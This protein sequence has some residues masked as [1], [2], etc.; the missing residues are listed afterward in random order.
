M[1]INVAK[2]LLTSSFL[3]V[4]FTTWSV[5]PV[6]VNYYQG[7]GD[8]SDRFN[9]I[10]ADGQGNYVAV[11]Y[12]IKTGDYRDFLIVKFNSN[13]DT[14]W[15]RTKNGKDF[16][17]DEAVDVVLDALGNVYACGYSDG[18]NSQDDILL[19]KYDAN[20]NELYDTTWN[21]SSYYMD[22]IPVA[23][24]IDG[25]QN[26]FI[27]GSTEPDTAKGSNNFITLKFNSSGGLI[28]Q[29]EYNRP[30]VTSGKDEAASI[31]VDSNGDAYITGR[32]SN[33]S[34]DDIVTI[35]YNGTDGSTLWT[36]IYNSGNGDDRGTSLVVDH[37]GDIIITGRSDNGS[38][39]DIRTV[40]YSSTGTLVWSRAYNGP[41]NQN[42]RGLGVIVDLNDNVLV[43]GQ[44]DSNNSA[45]IDYDYVTVKYNASGIIQWARFEASNA[46][47][48]DIPSA[49]AT[50]ASGNVFVTGKSD[51]D[52]GLNTDNDYM[53]VM[54]NSS[55]VKQWVKFHSGSRLAGS[56]IA[57]SLV[58]DDQGFVYVTGGSENNVTQK[59][60][61][62]VKYDLAGNEIWVKNLNGIGDFSE[63]ARAV[64]IDNNGNAY[65]GGYSFQ[66]GHNRDIAIHAM[67]NAGNTICTWLYN[68][69]KNDDDEIAAMAI[70]ASGFVYATGFTKVIDQKSDMITLKWNPATCDTV[71][72]RLY[73]YSAN[74]T[75]KGMSIVVDAAGN[76]YVTGR[77]DSN[78]NDTLDNDDIVTFKYD[79][80]GNLIWMQRYDGPGNKKDE[81][82]RIRLD[83][84]GNV[85]V[86]GRTEKANDD[87]FFL[88]KYNSITGNPVWS[89]PALFNGP[90]SN[91]DRALDMTIDSNDNIYVAG[92][93]QTGSAGSADDGLVIKYD[94]AGNLF[95]TQI[96]F[97][98]TFSGLGNDQAVGIV[99]N[100][101]N[102]I[103]VLY[104][105]DVNN[106][107]NT[108]NYNYLTI[109]YDDQFNQLWTTPPQ[110]DGPI[111]GD[112]IP[113]A[114]TASSTGDIFVTGYSE[115]DSAG[116]RK[117]QN[118]VTL[119]YNDQGVQ[120]MYENFDG[121][122]ATDDQPNAMAIRGSKLWVAGYAEGS[123]NNQKDLTTVTYDILTDVRYPSLASAQASIY[124]N[125]G[126]GIF[127]IS[128]AKDE[129]GNNPAIRITDVPG[130]VVMEQKGL[131][132]G[133]N[134]IDASALNPGVYVYSIS[135]KDGAVVASGTFIVQ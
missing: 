111:H 67:D 119:R 128:W 131:P 113:I 41:A 94:S 53:T 34:D 3:F 54:Y 19:V 90:F 69:N 48:D 51:Q 29:A 116:G 134:R 11:G 16:M 129:F 47:Q 105:T 121:P 120:T 31:A 21:N 99:H 76:S 52:P 70:D 108:S 59:D 80:N 14:L 124:P 132:G 133:V 18:G 82:S 45:T 135:S 9:K 32:S 46:L 44:Y 71:W 1:K 81:P 98:Y 60:A 33:G 103:F 126:S 35:K 84:S 79:T 93:M 87:D 50:D 75:D 88:V 61:T 117:N 57:S 27:T 102:E 28:W 100:Q 22:D 118:W 64:V 122:N 74:Q 10:K 37:A 112:D 2:F 115:N 123:N 4:A 73:N 43:C 127:H 42:D 104:E 110:Y 83:N 72:T 38:N 77:S 125:P 130:Q 6:W 92:Y 40:K 91:D 39:D 97:D 63:S 55:G 68:G 17:D 85:L 26:I 86:C 95:P 23:M 13:G 20:G 107:P 101:S 62:T 12:T 30:S 58:A 8:N 109:K 36:Q 24:A 96:Y 25:N 78:P 5:S 106:D 114:I 56:D 89:T 66:E 65:S 49:I 7:A 15:W